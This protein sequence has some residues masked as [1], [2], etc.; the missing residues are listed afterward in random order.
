MSFAVLSNRNM[1]SFPAV[2]LLDIILARSLLEMLGIV[3]S[4][5]F[6]LCLLIIMGSNPVPNDLANAASALCI[7]ALLGIGVGINVSIISS[8]F[9]FFANIYGLFTAL[10]YL[11]SGGPIFLHTF[12]SQLTDYASYNPAFHLVEWMRSAYYLGYPDQ[13]LDKPYVIAWAF[14]S[15]AVGLLMER[16]LRTHIING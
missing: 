16:I 13:Y 7:A 5:T 15:I 14:G 2:H 8:I 11:S 3:I 12:P 10:V 9:P 1:L 6:L 4:I